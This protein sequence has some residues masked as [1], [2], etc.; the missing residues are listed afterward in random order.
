[1]GY[2]PHGRHWWRSRSLLAL[3]VVVVLAS[4]FA[5]GCAGRGAQPQG[6]PTED[7]TLV[8][9]NNL[10]PT[11][12]DPHISN[13]AQSNIFTLAMY[14]TLLRYKPNS[15]ELEPWLAERYEVSKDGL[16]FTFYLRKG[17]KFHDGADL[18]AEAVKYSFERMKGVG[19]GLAF[20]LDPMAG[21]EAVDQYTVKITLS[22][23]SVPFLQTIPNVFIVSP[24]SFKAN[25][26]DNDWG[27]E[28]AY[29][30]VAG[31]GPYRL[32]FW[33][34]GRRL[35]VEKFPDYWRGW[36]GKH[37]ERLVLVVADEPGTRR[38]MLE[39]GD[40]DMMIKLEDQVDDVAALKAKE[41]ITVVINPT[42]SATYIAMACNRPPFSDVR[43]RK[44]VSYAFDY[45]THNDIAYGGY[46]LQAQGILP[47]SMKFHNDKLF[48][49]SCD[50]EK[51]RQLLAE[52]GYAGGFNAD[53]CYVG[54]SGVQRRTSE[55][56]QSSLAK[57]GIQV[58]PSPMTWPTLL[59]K[60]QDP[61]TVPDMY[62][63]NMHAAYPDPDY[64]LSRWVHSNA[65]GQRGFNGGCYSNPRVDQLIDQGLV[66]YDEREREAMYKEVQEILVE[67]APYI[68]VANP[69]YIVAMRSYVKNFSYVPAFSRTLGYVYDMYI[70]GKGR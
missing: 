63:L 10:D 22:K 40:V 6:Q 41:G 55:I 20:V 62:N 23:P 16:E 25:V 53:F 3:L 44:A 36:Q 58:A 56:L 30:H 29:N 14:E 50:P 18:D 45:Q 28:W 67:D 37:I 59:A 35:Q 33:E 49:Y 46:A 5:F 47:K 39:A 19:M 21:I 69:Q 17:V 54:S 52:A 9:V 60:F 43:V 61:K 57:V 8:F 34:R 26:K 1:M 42:L 15:T 27:R 48:M 68:W 70:E 24:K 7:Q 12:L 32:T 13:D 4:S 2:P 11:T 66:T 38:L 65:T 64:V 51:A 31:T